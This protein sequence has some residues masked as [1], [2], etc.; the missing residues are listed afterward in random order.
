MI[1]KKCEIP[2]SI[3]TYY[4]IDIGNTTFT[5]LRN[6]PVNNIRWLYFTWRLWNGSQKFD[7][8]WEIAQM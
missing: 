7:P 1:R 3:C 6:S 8:D 5:Q 4:S 2:K